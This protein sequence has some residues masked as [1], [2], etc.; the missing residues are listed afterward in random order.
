MLKNAVGKECT[1][2]LPTDYS[3]N[4]VTEHRFQLTFGGES[5][6]IY[7]S[8][9][10]SKTTIRTNICTMCVKNNAI[11]VANLRYCMHQ[12]LCNIHN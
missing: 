7:W 10:I 2:K 12:Q 11:I 5:Y 3:F 8:M 9:A 6:N 4:V 1:F